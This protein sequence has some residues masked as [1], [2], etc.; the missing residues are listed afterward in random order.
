MTA[1]II[2]T[3]LQKIDKLL[4]CCNLRCRQYIRV[5]IVCEAM[6]LQDKA[7]WKLLR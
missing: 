6:H 2:V 3:I 1:A 4:I 7:K 5:T